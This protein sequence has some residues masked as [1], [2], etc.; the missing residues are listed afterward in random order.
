[1]SRMT[2]SVRRC[3]AW[4][5]LP[6]QPPL[7]HWALAFTL[8]TVLSLTSADALVFALCAACVA[9]FAIS[10]VRRMEAVSRHQ[11]IHLALLLLSP[12][13]LGVGYWR[14]DDAALPTD[15]LATADLGGQTVRLEGVV[16]QDPQLR[17]SGMSFLLEAD[18]VEIGAEQRTVDDRV[19]LHVSDAIDVEYGDR[20]S[21]RAVLTPTS[22][23]ELEYLQ[24]LANQRISASGLARPGSVELLSRG[25][26]G[27]RQSVAADAR[28]ALNRSI[29]DSLPPP[30]SG[31]AQGMITGR[32]DAIDPELRSDLNDTSLSHL[33]VISGS[34]L[35]LLTTIV[36]AASAWL[37][38]RR[39]A[40]L[41]AIMAALAYGSLIGPDPPVQRAMWMAIVFAAAHMLGRG[42]SA[43]YAIAATAA[44]MVA[45]DPHVILDLSFQLTLAGTL[46]IIVLMPS[47]SQDFL[48]GQ[49]GI[50][51]AIRD[52]A[53]VTLVATLATMPLIALHFERAALIGLATNLVVTPI[54]SW[55]LLGS[56][57]TAVLG[58]ISE[59]LASTLAWPLAWLPLRWLVLVAERGAALPGGGTVIQGFGHVHLLLI[60]SA[61]VV[62]SFRTHPE[63]VGRWFRTTN[64]S[65]RTASW[66]PLAR[67]GLEVI[68]HL[69]SS[70]RPVCVAGIASAV[71]AGLWIS[72][73]SSGHDRLTAHFVD[74]GQ[75]DSALIVTPE[76]STIL[77]DT[78]ERSQDILSALRTYMPADSDRIDLVVITHPQSDHGEALWAIVDRYDIGQVLLNPYVDQTPFGRRLLD[79]LERRQIATRFSEPGQRIEFAGGTNLVLDV[80]WPPTSG[81]PAEYRA[82]PNS[83]S[84]VLRAQ[85]GEAAFLFTGDINVQQELALVRNPCPL[86]RS[87]CDLRADVLKV[88]HQGSRFSTSMLFLESVRPTLAIL[89]AGADNPHGHPHEDVLASLES[90]GAKPLLTSAQGDI[91]VA[92]DGHSISIVTQR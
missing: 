66:N 42:S 1:M 51:G 70:L 6:Y 12:V 43:F 8:G 35:T 92:T 74:V 22:N 11:R 37:V 10:S 40:A 88:A 38:G 85:F 31:I 77:I 4:P 32:R 53:L 80:L 49:R 55:M 28:Q 64:R 21:A 59:T 33:I 16:I 15:G 75:G 90:V 30:L 73:C 34:N 61:I 17:E 60:Y 84:I 78:G 2:S 27:W 63:R 71:A 9:L 89:S 52:A 82:D 26:L 39:S 68:P 36:M 65:A 83:T 57:A 48:S 5:K 46:G 44:L 56:A 86:S 29:R 41:L 24:W 91:S 81:L 50:T 76:G 14:A 87:P 20:I 23:S 67:V 19:Q 3:L 18:T 79:L 45:L 7:F 72:A 25:E 58:M 13:L 47:V 54:F 69:R 62:A